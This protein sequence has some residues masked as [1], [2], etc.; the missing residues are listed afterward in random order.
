MRSCFIKEEGIYNGPVQD[1][2][3]WAYYTR[4]SSDYSTECFDVFIAAQRGVSAVRNLG[5]NTKATLADKFCEIVQTS[6]TNFL[7]ILMPVF[8]DFHEYMLAVL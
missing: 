5:L 1:G 3:D 6:A 4:G 7:R 8:K 2:P